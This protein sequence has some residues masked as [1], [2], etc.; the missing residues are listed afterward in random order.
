MISKRVV[1]DISDFVNE[2]FLETE[3]GLVIDA[4]FTLER[5]NSYSKSDVPYVVNFYIKANYSYAVQ[6]IRS[7]TGMFL[8]P[9][10]FDMTAGKFTLACRSF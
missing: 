4:S 8:A 2:N 9:C 1:A 5:D 6:Y 7:Q 3:H 10:N